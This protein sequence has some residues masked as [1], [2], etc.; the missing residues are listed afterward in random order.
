MLG[1]MSWEST[2]EYYRLANQAVRERL[3]GLH[4]AAV[5]LDSV[6]FAEVERMQVEGRWDDAGRLLAEHAARLQDGGADVLLLCTN[7]MHKVLAPIEAAVAIPVLDI[8]EVGAAAVRGAGLARVGLLGTRFTMADGFYVDRL[9]AAGVAAIVPGDADMDLVHRVIYE[10]LCLGVLREESRQA[11]RAVI[12]RLVGAGAEGVLLACTE[13]ELLIGPQDSPV[14]VF[15]TTRLH[16]EAAV[17][18]ALAEAERPATNS[19]PVPR[20][21]VI[22]AVDVRR[23]AEFYRQLFGWRYRPGDEAPPAGPDTA[24]WLVLR[25]PDGGYGLAFQQVRT[26]TPTTWPDSE[27][28]MQLHL[29]CT[30]HT[31]ADLEAARVLALR[32]GARLLYDRSDDPDEALYV[33][34]DPEGHPFCIFVADDVPG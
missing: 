3:G 30:V 17:T 8:V 23:S 13:L 16:V 14:P 20:Q 9:R 29:D 12:D 34:A 5:L 24:D 7:T 33:F 15:P 6:D 4:S 10:E 22:D 2:T 19:Q 26:L 25:A 31:V 18:Y 11:V 32:L 21:T 28:P 1:G 27:V